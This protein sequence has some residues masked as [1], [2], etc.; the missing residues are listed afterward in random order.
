MRDRIA[1]LAE[2]ATSCCD[3]PEDRMYHAKDNTWW[4]RVEDYG[5]IKWVAADPPTG[6]IKVNNESEP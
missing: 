6:W 5:K 4:K 1:E 2:F 3:D